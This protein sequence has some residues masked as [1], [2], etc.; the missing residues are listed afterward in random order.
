MKEAYLN[1]DYKVFLD[2]GKT[3]NLEIG[4]K[5]SVLLK[6][7]T[8]LKCWAFITAW[9]PYPEVLSVEIN[10]K[11]NA[12]LEHILKENNYEFTRGIGVAK[13]ESWQEE[14]LLVLNITK[15]KAHE[16][17]KKFNQLA[18]VYGEINGVAKLLFTD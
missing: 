7:M 13:D 2:D 15:D 17:A 4:K 10:R 6:H 8:T 1:T 9:N 16:I 3:V 18:F 14:S 11:R 12:E 5:P